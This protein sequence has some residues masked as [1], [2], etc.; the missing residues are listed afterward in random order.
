[1]SVSCQDDASGMLHSPAVCVEAAG[2]SAMVP[3]SSS[4]PDLL[5]R[6]WRM[7]L[8][9]YCCQ[10][11]WQRSTVSIK[12]KICLHIKID[13][14]MPLFKTK[15]FNFCHRPY[16]SCCHSAKQHSEVKQIEHLFV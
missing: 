2:G 4:H 1:M 16:L 5:P 8:S 7:E 6:K 9:G 10:N 3:G 13:V 11:N 12:E 15:K 14:I